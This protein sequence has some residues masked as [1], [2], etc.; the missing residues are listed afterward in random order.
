MAEKIKKIVN[1]RLRP[2][3]EERIK[4]DR[5]AKREGVRDALRRRD[6]FDGAL[7]CSQLSYWALFG[8]FPLLDSLRSFTTC[9]V[10]GQ[11]FDR[12]AQPLRSFFPFLKHANFNGRT[13]SQC[14][15]QSGVMNKSRIG[16]ENR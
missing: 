3:Q 11:A 12:H 6:L 5:G 13:L 2:D 4:C 15:E 8:S 9:G 16:S 14:G 7:V 1:I 10:R